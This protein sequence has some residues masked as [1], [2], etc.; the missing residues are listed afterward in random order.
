MPFCAMHQSV[1]ERIT[2]S[3][4]PSGYGRCCA[5]PTAKRAFRTPASRAFFFAAAIPSTSGS[6]PST[7]AAKAATPS[8]KRPSPHPRSRM[9]FPRTSRSPPH[10]RSSSTGRGRSV[11]ETAGTCFPTSPTR[12][13]ARVL[14]FACSLH[15]AFVTRRR[16]RSG[17]GEFWSGGR[18]TDMEGHVKST[19]VVERRAGRW[20]GAQ[21]RAGTDDGNHPDIR[22]SAKPL[23]QSSETS[24]PSRLGLIGAS[25]LSQSVLEDSRRE[26]PTSTAPRT[27]CESS[28]T[29]RHALADGPDEAGELTTHR[30]YR[31]GSTDAAIEVSVAS[32]KSVLSCDRESD[33]VCWDIFESP[34]E[35][36]FEA[37]REASVVSSLVQ[38][39][40]N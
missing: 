5:A 11:E 22:R 16:V 19:P 14:T 23:P 29:R 15:L 21:P 28:C 13:A 24:P 7:L 4:A 12:L 32:M 9:R 36:A 40:A 1:H 25:W 31:L 17:R 33:Q 27:S 38:N 6:S 2:K 20:L 26:L 3:K 39:V 34:L 18:D 37:R 10:S 30:S 8:A 35:L